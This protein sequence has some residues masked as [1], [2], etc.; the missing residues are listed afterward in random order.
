MYPAQEGFSLKNVFNTFGRLALRGLGNWHNA[1]FV[2]LHI[3][4]LFSPTLELTKPE[5]LKS[6]QKSSGLCWTTLSAEH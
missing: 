3:S 5:N 2:S 4:I 1:L 6:C